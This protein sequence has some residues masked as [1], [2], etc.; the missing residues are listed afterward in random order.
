MDRLKQLNLTYNKI[1]DISGLEQICSNLKILHLSNNE[2][3][4]IQDI[5]KMQTLREIDLSF[6]QIEELPEGWEEIIPLKSINLSI[7][8]LTKVLIKLNGF[9]TFHFSSNS[10]S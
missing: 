6:N 10:K 1:N 8:V 9:P 5:I 4:N 2:I 7:F 3:K